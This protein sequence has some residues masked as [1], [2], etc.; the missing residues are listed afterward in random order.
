MIN[1]TGPALT[2]STFSRSS[3]C[4]PQVVHTL[5]GCRV[6]K[7]R[8]H[9]PDD[10]RRHCRYASRGMVSLLAHVVEDRR[11]LVA[12]RVQFSAARLSSSWASLV[13]PITSEAIPGRVR[14][15][16]SAT[17]ATLAPAGGHL[18]HHLQGL[19]GS[20]AVGDRRGFERR[21]VRQ[22]ERRR[23]R[24]DHVPRSGRPPNGTAGSPGRCRSAWGLRQRLGRTPA[25]ARRPGR[26]TP[27][28]CRTVRRDS[29]G[30]GSPLR[31]PGA[32]PNPR[33][34]AAARVRPR[35][36]QGALPQRRH[37]ARPR[38]RRPQRRAPQ[39]SR[40]ISRDAAA[41]DGSTRRAG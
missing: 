14:S 1:P 35:L 36:N 20:L 29:A 30:M 38:H 10:R 31:A 24:R 11:L 7:D 3:L 23:G 40:T 13:A 37:S 12:Q 39:D 25:P 26:V 28:P 19:P 8:Y 41:P 21:G 4:M 15:Q 34:S 22:G 17:C 6:I 2:M 27:A 32:L 33:V 5:P 16:L 18:L 9:R